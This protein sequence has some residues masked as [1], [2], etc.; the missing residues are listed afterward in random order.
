[1]RATEQRSGHYTMHYLSLF[2]LS[3]GF[4]AL[5]RIGLLLADDF[6][7]MPPHWLLVLTQCAG[8]YW[9]ELTASTSLMSYGDAR[10]T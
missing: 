3:S 4:S 5:S 9:S 2:S 10:Q 6:K 8:K 7:G 1:V